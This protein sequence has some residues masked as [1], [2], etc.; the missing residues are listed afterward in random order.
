MRATSETRHNEAD[1]TVSWRSWRDE[2]VRSSAL[3]PLRRSSRGMA[4]GVE[5][6]E[7]TSAFRASVGAGSLFMV[8]EEV[9]DRGR[10]G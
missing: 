2:V 7:E 4:D 5:E 1:K 9:Q 10:D 6:S 8:G 3:S